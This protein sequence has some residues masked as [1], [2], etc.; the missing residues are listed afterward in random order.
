M[1]TESGYEVFFDLDK[2]EARVYT[3]DF[4]LGT[5]VAVPNLLVERAPPGG[6]RMTVQSVFERL[7]QIDLVVPVVVLYDPS[8]TTSANGLAA[9]NGE[10]SLALKVGHRDTSNWF[11]PFTAKVKGE[12]TTRGGQRRSGGTD[13]FPRYSGSGGGGP[14][15]SPPHH[16]QN[17]SQG[18]GRYNN[19]N[20]NSVH[21]RGG[22]GRRD[23]Y[24]VRRY[25]H[26]HNHNPNHN[27]PPPP[28]SYYEGG[29]TPYGGYGNN[30]GQTHYG[31][32]AY[33]GPTSTTSS[34][35]HS[36]VGYERQA[37]ATPTSTTISPLPERPAHTP[38]PWT[39]PGAEV[40][41]TTPTTIYSPFVRARHIVNVI[42]GSSF[43]IALVSAFNKQH[44]CS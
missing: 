40:P 18:Y 14:S 12:F 37:W 11:V 22:G 4:C 16:S 34:A 25:N 2:N 41:S 33:Y 35:D 23:E 7:R 15:P 1:S 27:Y 13:A 8:M 31:G 9:P 21:H 3:Q 17:R 28:S 29:G 10:T 5:A 32:S 19:N 30:G 42:M 38:A 39:L 20:P 26:N 43:A 36:F 44:P 6:K 24:Q